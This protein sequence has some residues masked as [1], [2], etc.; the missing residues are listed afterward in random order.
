MP[1]KAWFQA[2]HKTSLNI[3]QTINFILK[4]EGAIIQLFST[5]Y[6]VLQ[7]KNSMR[8]VFAMNP[9]LTESTGNK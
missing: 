9:V 4:G 6:T 8:S 5:C 7:I 2:R 1:Q 3:F